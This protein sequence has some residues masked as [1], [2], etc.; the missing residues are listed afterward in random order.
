VRSERGINNDDDDDDDDDDNNNNNNNNKYTN[1]VTLSFKVYLSLIV[2]LQ[3][4][5]TRTL[6]IRVK[7]PQ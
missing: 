2:Q 1:A 7:L 4:K 3:Y 6:H 5:I